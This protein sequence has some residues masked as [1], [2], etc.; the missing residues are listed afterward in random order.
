MLANEEKNAES[1][2]VAF[3]T[4]G[5]SSGIYFYKLQAGNASTSSGRGFVEIKRMIL[6]K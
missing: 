3:N 2:E 4:V 1:Y 5:L 6:I